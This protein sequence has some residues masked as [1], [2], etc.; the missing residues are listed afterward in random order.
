MFK[1]VWRFIRRKELGCVKISPRLTNVARITVCTVKLVK[2]RKNGQQKTCILFCNIA[3]KR[4]EK[5]S[6]AY[7]HP[8]S[9]LLTTWF[10]ARQVLCGWYNV[11][12]RYSTRFCK[13]SC[14]FFVAPF[15]VPWATHVRSP[16]GKG[17]F[18]LKKFLILKTSLML[19]SLRASRIRQTS[20][21]SQN[22]K[23]A[24]KTSS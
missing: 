24:E 16:Y 3:A 9:N 23:W 18:T 6:C 10:V 21:I 5:R 4:V 15:S 11:Q 8:G 20:R 13:T 12:H 7:Y 1:N 17:S 19:E 2:L 14:T 22:R